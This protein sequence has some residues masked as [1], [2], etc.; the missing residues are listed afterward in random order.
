MFWSCF[1]Y[2]T[3]EPCHIYYK[4]TAKQKLHYQKIINNLNN[5]EIKKE[6]QLAFAEQKK[7]KEKA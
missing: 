5:I 1:S 7:L 3:K 4:K 6:G 2:D